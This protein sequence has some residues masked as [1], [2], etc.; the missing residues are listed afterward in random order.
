MDAPLTL[1]DLFTGLKKNYLREFQKVQLFLY[2]HVLPDEGPGTGGYNALL[3]LYS[4]TEDSSRGDSLSL[5]SDCAG[6][7]PRPFW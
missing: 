3:P 6:P 4:G 7:S 5:T 1:R 2:F